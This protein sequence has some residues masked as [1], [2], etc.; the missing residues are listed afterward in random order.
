MSRSAQLRCV[1]A[2]FDRGGQMIA[3][4]RFR[5]CAVR[6][7]SC[8]RVRRRAAGGSLAC[9]FQAT[10]WPLADGDVAV[11]VAPCPYG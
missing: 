9:T 2:V 5:P 8:R 10:R 3:A 6:T 7:Q 1:D 11:F 4:E